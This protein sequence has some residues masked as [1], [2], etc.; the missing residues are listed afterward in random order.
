MG[1]YANPQE[2]YEYYN[3]PYCAPL[4]EHHLDNSKGSTKQGL[5]NQLKSASVGEYLGGHVL[6]HSGHSLHFASYATKEKCTNDHVLTNEE[7]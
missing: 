5:L 6:R 4:N 3:L 1:P 2:A 7:T